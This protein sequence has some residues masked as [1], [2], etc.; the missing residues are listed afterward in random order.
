MGD[1][2]ALY[3]PRGMPGVAADA[4]R[5]AI[6]AEGAWTL[7]FEAYQL[8]VYVKGPRAPKVRALPDQ[9]GVVIG[10]LFDTAA[11]REGRVQ[12]FPIALIKD[13]A[14]QDAARIL[15]THAWGRYVAVLKA[16]DR[17]PWIFR[18]PSGAVE[19]LAWVRD[20]VTIISS[21]VAAQ[22]AWSPD[23]LAIDWS[24][25]GRVLARGNL[26]GEICPLAGVTAIAPGTARCDLGDA[27]LSL[28]RPGDH[29]RRSRHD[30]SP[31]DL[32]RVVDASVA[33]LARDRSAI[34]VEISGGLDS[35]IV[36]TSLARCGAPVV[37]G[38]NHYWPEPEGDERR[39]AQDIA[40]RCG[41]RLIA[42]QRQ[43]LLLDEAKLLR[44]AQG[45]RPGL[46]AQDPD[47]DHDLAEQA[48]ALG[49]DALFSG[50]GGDGVFYQMANAA[51][52]ADILM[53]KPAPM[54]RAASLAA[55]ARRA[56]ATVWSLCGQAM[57]PSRAFAAGMPPPSFLS[58]GLAPPPVHPW[59]ADQRGVSPAK[60]IQIRGLTNI[61][62]AFGD[63]LRGRAADLLYPLMAQPVMELC[64]S[65]PAPLLA[66]GAL[67][68]PFARAAFADRLPPRSLVRRSKGDVTVFFSKSLAASLPALRPFLLDGRLAEQGLIDRAK[69][70]PL[71]HPEPMIWRDSV[72]EVMLAAYLEAWVRAWEAKLRVS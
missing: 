18:D 6:E 38:I 56:R 65:I 10:E 43:R 16:G 51:L 25:L 9:G 2:L 53:G 55:V 7:A 48:K 26:W 39:W 11:T 4:M 21:D 71:L 58:A 5:A 54:G 67:D 31:R 40:D 24:G 22:R 20:E 69:L 12:D 70:E 42:G 62:C 32:A 46:N 8:V 66:V 45:P 28:W 49:A 14:A 60:R 23:R 47:L 19:C 35:A 13:V 63:S 17:P 68:R 37:A 15:A 59:I 29:A 27:A 52:A 36:A 3:W 41:F 44:H 61:Q 57:F 30:V 50:Q 33:A 72:G 34:L 64:L 1:Y